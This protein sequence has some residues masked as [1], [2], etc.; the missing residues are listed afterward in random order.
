M[1]RW[2]DRK[3]LH[4]SNYDG[5]VRERLSVCGENSIWWPNRLRHRLQRICYLATNIRITSRRSSSERYRPTPSY[6][7]GIH[8]KSRLAILRQDTDCK[9]KMRIGWYNC[10]RNR[11]PICKADY[12]YSSFY[13][14]ESRNLRH[15]WTT[16]SWEA[17]RY[18]VTLRC[19]DTADRWHATTRKTASNSVPIGCRLFWYC[20]LISENIFG[21]QNENNL[22]RKNRPAKFR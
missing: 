17:R 4:W 12:A 5:L 14:R 10:S 7:S 6:R 3:R 18:M 2:T 15:F 22:L 11:W 20:R 21:I 13:I 9:A 16:G 8:A 19:T 1:T